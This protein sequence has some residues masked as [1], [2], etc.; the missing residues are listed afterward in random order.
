MYATTSASDA[1]HA[2]QRA[3]AALLVEVDDVDVGHS[4]ASACATARVPSVLALSAIV[5]RDG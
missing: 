1:I 5:I 2:A 4:S 3:A